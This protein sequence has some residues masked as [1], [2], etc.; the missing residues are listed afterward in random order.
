M[1]PVGTVVPACELAACMAE[2]GN[3]SKVVA[4]TLSKAGSADSILMGASL[5][6][7]LQP[8]LKPPMNSKSTI[9][10]AINPMILNVFIV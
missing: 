8:S 4:V 1:N 2:S 7:S 6:T 10:R 3:T 9:N 5:S